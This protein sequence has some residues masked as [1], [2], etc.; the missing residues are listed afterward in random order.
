M[1]R[2]LNPAIL[3]VILTVCDSSLAGN[4]Q[5]AESRQFKQI[6]DDRLG[7]SWYWKT[8]ERIPNLPVGTIRVRL[9]ADRDG[10]I[11]NLRVLSNTSDQVFADLTLA[12]IRKT[13]L[14]AIP[15]DLLIE[16]KFEYECSFA[17]NP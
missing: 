17:I 15:P 6:L 7:A 4:P 1:R 14:P 2:R 8:Q 16:G 13:K 9:T 3:L 5:T 11:L 10:K 12:A